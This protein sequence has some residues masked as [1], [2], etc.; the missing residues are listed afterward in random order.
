MFKRFLKYL[1]VK[2]FNLIFLIPFVLAKSGLAEPQLVFT[3]LLA[4]HS[5]F[6]AIFILSTLCTLF[7]WWPTQ[8]INRKISYTLWGKLFNKRFGFQI[9][10]YIIIIGQIKSQVKSVSTDLF[11]SY[12]S[13]P[14]PSLKKPWLYQAAGS[15]N[16]YHRPI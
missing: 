10:S 2:S 15:V 14:Q 16:N 6:C 13:S 12:L 3:F 7:D 11:F 4:T 8:E 9:G 1:K 5:I